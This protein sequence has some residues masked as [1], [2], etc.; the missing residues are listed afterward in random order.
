MNFLEYPHM[1]ITVC[2]SIFL[3]MGFSGLYF[4][5]KSIKTL[6]EVEEKSFCSNAKIES[7]FAKA[8]AVRKTHSVV[9]IALSLDSAYSQ[10]KGTGLY[11]QVKR[12]LLRY[13]CVYADG[14]ISL[15]GKES[16][17]AYNTLEETELIRLMDACDRDINETFTKFGAVGVARINFGY[18][19]TG[20]NEVAYKMALVRAKQACSMAQ[21][22]KTTYCRWDSTSSKAF[23]RKISIGNSICSDIDNNRFYLEYQPIVDAKTHKIVG[24]EVLA[25]LRSSE[26]GILA[27]R[28]FLPAVNSADIN[29]KF[30]YYIFEKNCKWIASDKE[31]RM[32]YI[33]T[34][35]FSRHTLCDP[36]FTARI[37]EIVEKYGI[38]YSCI[39]VEIIED[40]GLVGAEKT[41]MIQNVV[42]LKKKGVMILLDDFGK[43]CTSFEDLLELDIDI[44]KIDK[45]ITRNSTNQAGLAILKD[46]IRTVRDLEYQ[47]LCEG[48]ETEEEKNT[49]T[50]AG[51][52][53]FQGFYLYRPMPASQL[54]KLLEKNGALCP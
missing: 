52:D 48:I 15:N 32:N 21:D 45:S 2:V 5:M 7:A 25:R 41:A 40:I 39:A 20:S 17:I 37:I 8:M 28:Y 34:I 33:Y 30:D 4:T 35:N 11:E 26:E 10:V 3:F 12:V 50:N 46:I 36:N 27:P 19:L 24:A 14:Y 23:D 29:W 18:C 43:G 22:K 38:S 31:N 6:K 42:M 53:F 1:I 9:Y 44:V 16:F 49:V 13:F 47:V 54:E 51:C